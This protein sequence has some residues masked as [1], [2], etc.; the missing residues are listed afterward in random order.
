MNLLYQN[1]NPRPDT[2]CGQC[3]PLIGTV[4]EPGTEPPLPAHPL[5]Y[6]YYFATA[7]APTQSGWNWAATSP[8]FRDDWV[9]TLVRLLREG[10]EII[11]PFLAPLL[12]DA[13]EYIRDHPEPPEEEPME[14]QHRHRLATG[15]AYPDELEPRQ[16][17]VVLIEAGENHN[18][19]IMPADV[20]RDALPLFDG[21]PCLVDHASFLSRPSLR[22]YAGHYSRINQDT[23][24]NI[25]AMLTLK[26]NEPGRFLAQVFD[27]WIEDRDAD[28]WHC[29][30][31]GLSAD[32]TVSFDYDET[33]PIATRVH[34]VW[35]VDAVLHPAA[36][37]RVERVLN[38]IQ[39]PRAPQEETM[40]EEQLQY[41]ASDV[42]PQHQPPPTQPLTGDS[43]ARILPTIET[44]VGRVADLATQVDTLQVQ[45]AEQQ[46]QRTITGLG[47]PPRT[48]GMRTS[49]DQIE[50]ALDC[51]LSGVRPPGNIPPLTGIREL[52]HLLSGDYEMTGVY[53]PERVSLAYVNCSTMAGLVANAMNKRVVNEF[54]T[55]PQW[56]TKIVIEEDFATLQD[57]RWVTLGGVGELPTVAEGASYTELTWD[58]ATETD[59]FV[60]K[61]GY[62]GLTIEA[63]DKDDTTRIRRAPRALAQAA[64]LTLSKAVSAI[65]TSASGVGPDMADSVALFHADHSNLG[66]T[67]L[68]WAEWIVV[69]TAMRKQTELNS[70]ERLGVLTAPKYILV[71]PDLEVTALQVLASEGQPGTANNDENVFAQGNAH[72][73]RMAHA[74]DRVIVVDLWTDTNN[75]AAVADPILYPSIGIG[76]RYGR[77]PEIFSVASPTAGLM[78]SND[79]MPVKVRFFYAVGPT[80]YRGLYKENVT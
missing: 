57:V 56:W 33:P 19:W 12:A 50:T 68:S 38:S 35:S 20:L 74:R 47:D 7:D 77:T 30:P 27:G 78:F 13:L 40:P 49:L 31:I 65:F 52:Y 60:K 45:L 69:R 55:Y 15:Y 26:D 14:L 61:G 17:A 71:P 58:D 4:W 44:L 1:A 53:Q 59:A 46:A 25:H 54:Q 62:L 76:Y 24:G 51:L 67:A 72:N 28:T 22:D 66:T 41:N 32:F 3:S 29:P 23:T 73:A 5:C 8:D 79:T 75:W 70:G 80:D 43:F 42:G 18:G 6:C 39:G 16:Y 64:W 63:I 2:I 21:A 37:G 36:G 9:M 48:S 10:A 34:Q 11:P